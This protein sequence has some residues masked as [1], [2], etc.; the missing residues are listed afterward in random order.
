MPSY[1][2]VAV[3]RQ[4][5]EITLEALARRAGMHPAVVE[6][7]VEFG[8][9]VPSGRQAGAP[10]FDP[11]ALRRLRVISHMRESL[12]INLAGISVILDLLD[13]M[14]ALQRANDRLRQVR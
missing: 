6:Q 14:G 3:A 11:S 12:G 2:I 9:I 5:S 4:R 13:K 1:A 10:L 8:L 7:V